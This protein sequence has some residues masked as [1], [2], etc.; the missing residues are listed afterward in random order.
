MTKSPPKGLPCNTITFGVK[1]SVYDFGGEYTNIQSITEFWS[2]GKIYA[3]VLRW[4]GGFKKLRPGWLEL[5][6][7][8]RGLTL[9]SCQISR[10]Q[11]IQGLVVSSGFCD[12]FKKNGEWFEGFNQGNN[13]MIIFLFETSLILVWRMDMGQELGGQWGGCCLVQVRSHHSVD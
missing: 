7:S 11:I 12:Y 10:G 8:S 13:T 6:W 1:I 2:S 9:C 4:V 3:N 5:Q